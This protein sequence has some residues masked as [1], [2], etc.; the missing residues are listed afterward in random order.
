[1]PMVS[2]AAAIE[3][4][5]LCFSAEVDRSMRQPYKQKRQYVRRIIDYYESLE[6]KYD[7]K[8]ESYRSPVLPYADT[9][10]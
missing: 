4:L 6:K 2:R 10:M 8:E 7:V 3:F 1:M 5:S 9:I